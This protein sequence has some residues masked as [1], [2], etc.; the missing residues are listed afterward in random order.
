MCGRRC[1]SCLPLHVDNDG[2]RGQKHARQADEKHQIAHV[3]HTAG[4]GAKMGQKLKPAS[5][6]TTPPVPSRETAQ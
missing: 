5:V 1:I 4:Y 2:S 6:S 3:D